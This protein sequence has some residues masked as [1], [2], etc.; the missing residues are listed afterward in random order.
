MRVGTIGFVFWFGNYARNI[1][2]ALNS[3]KMS[4]EY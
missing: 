2:D 4:K 3:F 1:G